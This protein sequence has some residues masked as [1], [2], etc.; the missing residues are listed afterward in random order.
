M[1][2]FSL[3]QLFGL[4]K[5]KNKFIFEV[6]SVFGDKLT[7]EELEYWFV[8]NII[9]TATIY[10]VDISNMPFEDAMEEIENAHR[11]KNTK[12]QKSR[13]SSQKKLSSPRG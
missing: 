2:D 11:K 5:D 7:I 9:S 13:K 1:H 12:W 10:D 6:S 4:C 3:R 8:Y